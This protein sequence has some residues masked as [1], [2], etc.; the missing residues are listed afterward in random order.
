[1]VLL[2]CSDHDVPVPGRHRQLQRTGLIVTAAAASV[3]VVATG[4][5]AGYRELSGK[6]C[7][8]T[9]TLRVTAAPEIAPAVRAVAGTWTQTGDAK[10]DSACVTVAV[11]AADAPSTAAAIAAQ[12]GVSLQGVGAQPDNSADTDAWIP[13]SATWLL[14]LASDAPGFIPANTGSIAT[15]PVVLAVPQPAAAAGRTPGLKEVVKQIV[16]DRTLRPGIVDPARDAAGLSGLLALAA[17]AG[18]DA[19][20]GAVKVGVMRAFAVNSSS[21][22]ADMLQKFPRSE[23]DIANSIGM[24]PLSEEDVITYNASKPP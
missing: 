18:N 19:A 12:H 22:R 3:V 15:S 7:S 13:D 6:D 4:S 11:S 8:S 20:A 17:A 16:T 14:R 2:H 23:S 9:V 1:M 24:A 5:W 10:V 21:I